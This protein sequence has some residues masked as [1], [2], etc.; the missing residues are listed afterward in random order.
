MAWMDKPDSSYDSH[1]HNGDESLYMIDGVLEFTDRA[2]DVTHVLKPGDKLF[3]PAGVVH[4]VKSEAGATYILGLS[5]LS[6]FDE[7]FIPAE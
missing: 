3:L 4:S 1:F 7:H 5:I 2:A 6:P